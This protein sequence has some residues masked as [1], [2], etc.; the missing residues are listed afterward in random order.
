MSLSGPSC[1]SEGINSFGGGWTP[2]VRLEGVPIDHIDRASEKSGDVSLQ[3]R[4]SEGVE[5]RV[6]GEL[7]QDVEIA[8]RTGLTSGHGAEK[9]SMV[10]TAG[11]ERIGI[12]LKN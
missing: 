10:H 2:Q 5:L 3:S 8:S 7:D 4:V 11:A 9:C 12:R 1:E 6:R